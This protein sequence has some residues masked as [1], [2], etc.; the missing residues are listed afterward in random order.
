VKNDFVRALQVFPT[1][2]EQTMRWEIARKTKV[3]L[4]VVK[5]IGTAI[6]VCA[7]VS[8]QYRVYGMRSANYLSPR[9]HSRDLKIYSP[10]T[11]PNMIKIVSPAI[12][13]QNIPKIV[14]IILE[15][16]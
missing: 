4:T 10:T 14:I 5:R 8:K 12:V 6:Y 9:D 2:A 13:S 1:I 15:C 16:M 7:V 3:S 11:M